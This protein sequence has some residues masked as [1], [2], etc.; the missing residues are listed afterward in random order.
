MVIAPP[1]MASPSHEAPSPERGVTPQRPSP[2]ITRLKAGLKGKTGTELN[3]VAKNLLT[4]IHSRRTSTTPVLERS[5]QSLKRKPEENKATSSSDVGIIEAGEV[6]VRGVVQE[7]AARTPAGRSSPPRPNHHGGKSGATLALLAAEA[8]KLLADG[9][10]PSPAEATGTERSSPPVGPPP[11][12][13]KTRE[14]LRLIKRTT[15]GPVGHK[16]GHPRREDKA[17]SEQTGSVQSVPSSPPPIRLI[18]ATLVGDMGRKLPTRGSSFPTRRP[19]H[20]PS[21]ALPK[22]PSIMPPPI[23]RPESPSVAPPISNSTPEPAPLNLAQYRT[24]P[25]R[26]DS[27]WDFF[28]EP[29]PGREDDLSRL[30]LE[31]MFGSELEPIDLTIDESLS[32]SAAATDAQHHFHSDNIDE[33]SLPNDA[34]NMTNPANP[35]NGNAPTDDSTSQSY[36]S[37]QE[38]FEEMEANWRNALDPTY[39]PQTFPFENGQRGS[40]WHTGLETEI[41]PQGFFFQCIKEINEAN[42]LIGGD[43]PSSAGARQAQGQEI[44]DNIPNRKR[45]DGQPNCPSGSD[46]PHEISYELEDRFGIHTSWENSYTYEEA[47]HF[48]GLKQPQPLRNGMTVNLRQLEIEPNPFA[49]DGNDID[50]NLEDWIHPHLLQDPHEEGPQDLHEEGPAPKH[51]DNSDKQ[52]NIDSKKRKSTDQGQPEPEAGRRLSVEDVFS[53]NSGK[54][55]RVD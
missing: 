52:E 19:P 29:P 49:D 51:T 40:A 7:E 39:I 28:D 20:I 27:F 4:Q 5:P 1:H 6:E 53:I 48:S 41:D 24:L 3:V 26:I 44:L 10:P 15:K 11:A 18:P 37:T 47:I 35:L 46:C 13:G 30:D 32:S 14:T 22:T 8:E 9:L 17:V 50:W 55:L 45:K 42:P 43:G 34:T 54:R 16:R 23:P 2:A 31:K 21:R 33:V 25:Q 38:I 12:G 36:I